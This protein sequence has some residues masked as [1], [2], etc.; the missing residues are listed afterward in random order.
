MNKGNNNGPA[1][2][3]ATTTDL[4]GRVA[5]DCAAYVTPSEPLNG[6]DHRYWQ[7]LQAFVFCS[8]DIASPHRSRRSEHQDKHEWQPL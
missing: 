1:V 7:E 4:E 2:F 8:S 3:A 5:Q 6:A